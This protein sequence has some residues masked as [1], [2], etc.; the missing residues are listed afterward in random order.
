MSR[1]HLELFSSSICKSVGNINDPNALQFRATY[2]K[3]FSTHTEPSK[4]ANSTGCDLK[5]LLS[6]AINNTFNSCGTVMTNII[7]YQNMKN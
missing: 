2:R 7:I 5:A 4:Y 6:A 3:C 1:D